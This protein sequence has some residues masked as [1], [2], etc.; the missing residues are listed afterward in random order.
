MVFGKRTST[1]TRLES[2]KSALSIGLNNLLLGSGLG[3]AQKMVTTSVLD[4]TY[5]TVLVETGLIGLAAFLWICFKSTRR[6][7]L[8]SKS[9]ENTVYAPFLVMCIIMMVEMIAESILYNSLL[10][11]FFGMIWYLAFS[12]SQSNRVFSEERYIMSA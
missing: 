11:I 8:L 1:S 3:K 7:S 6:I 12:A 2:F 10:N 5:L 9:S 4:S